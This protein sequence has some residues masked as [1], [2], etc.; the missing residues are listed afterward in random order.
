MP[1]F[2]LFYDV[3]DNFTARRT[4]YRAEHLKKVREAQG[5][6]ELILAGALEEPPGALLV[7]R[8][9]DRATPEQFATADPYVTG[10]LVTRWHVRPWAVVTGHEA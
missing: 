3:V 1:Y 9:S 5:R 4:P 6:G 10:G 7:F 8:S 2:A